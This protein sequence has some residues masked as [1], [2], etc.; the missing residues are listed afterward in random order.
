MP[1]IETNNTKDQ[2]FHVGD[3]VIVQHNG[4]TFKGV[5]DMLTTHGL[6]IIPDGY[7]NAEWFPLYFGKTVFTKISWDKK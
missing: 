5:V 6:Y 2:E 1:A 7:T 4:D 3:K